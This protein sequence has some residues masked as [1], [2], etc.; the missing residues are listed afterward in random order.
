MKK[1]GLTQKGDDEVEI[2]H[3]LYTAMRFNFL[4]VDRYVFRSGWIYPNSY[5]PYTMVRYILKGSAE[6]ILNGKSFY[7]HEKQVIYIPE[8]CYLECHALEDYFEFISI[9]FKVTTQLATDNFLQEYY[10]IQTVNNCGQQDEMERHFQEVYRNATSQHPSKVFHIRENL[11]L[12]VAWLVDQVAGDVQRMERPTVEYSFE[13]TLQ[14]EEDLEAYRQ[15][16]RINVLVDYIVTHPTEHY[17]SEV[18]CQ[19]V[20]VSPSTLRRLFKKHTGKSPSDFIQDLRLTVAARRLLV[21][22]DRISSIAY[23]VGFEDPNYFSRIF[24]KNFGVSPQAYRKNAQ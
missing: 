1:S 7:V 19:M 20:N 9:R 12:I 21:T 23:Q 6:F 18:L 11:E 14:K 8:G 5:I 16:P 13:R 24:Q 3:A 22:N 4:Y 10:R 15:D 2:E 17:T